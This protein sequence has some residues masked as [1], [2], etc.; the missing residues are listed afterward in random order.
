MTK[1]DVKRIEGLVKTKALE[2]A[3]VEK[4]TQ[5]KDDKVKLDT[6]HLKTAMEEFIQVVTK[7][8]Q[9]WKT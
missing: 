5:M 2:G 3:E 4:L 1:Q 6:E 7:A 9:K 8:E